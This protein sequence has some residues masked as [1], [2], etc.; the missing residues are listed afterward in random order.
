MQ[1]NGL[2]LRPPGIQASIP[3][4]LASCLQTIPL[5][6]PDPHRIDRIDQL[7]PQTQCTQCGYPRCRE[8]ATAI[9]A[10]EADINQCPP[11]ADITIG[12]LAKF[13]GKPP[14]PLNPENGVVEPKVLAVIDEPACI[15]CKLCIKACPVDCI[16][17]AEKRMHTV[18][19]RECTGCKLCVPVCPT[20]CISLVPAPAPDSAEPPSRWP[21]FSLDQTRKARRMVEQKLA[22]EAEEEDRKQ[23][24]RI[25]Q[26]RRIMKREIELALARKRSERQKKLDRQKTARNR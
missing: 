19:E 5:P 4:C 1:G 6:S 17:G 14:K 25:D 21:A 7:L 24:K 23:A 20:D 12:A 2:S 8:Y 18:I 9:A 11:G 13:T 22:R 10:G 15:G 3:R 26:R 16:V